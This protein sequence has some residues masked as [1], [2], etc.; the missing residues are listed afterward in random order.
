MSPYVCTSGTS[1]TCELQ[2]CSSVSDCTNV[3]QGND[4]AACTNGYC[5]NGAGTEC[6]LPEQCGTTAECVEDTTMYGLCVAL[7]AST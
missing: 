2:S 5:T 4:G 6:V 7:P 3:E 1:G